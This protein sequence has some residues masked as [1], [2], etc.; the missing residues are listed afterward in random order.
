MTLRFQIS[1]L[2][3]LLIT[4]SIG[5]FTLLDWYHG[6]TEYIE[7]QYRTC[8]SL[9]VLLE[10]FA[11]TNQSAIEQ[12]LAEPNHEQQLTMLNQ[13]L[14]PPVNRI[15]NGFPRTGAGYYIRQVQAVVAFGPNFHPS[16]LIDLS[17]ESQARQIY[18]NG[19]DL[20]FDGYS[21]TR[22]AHVF[23]YM[24]PIY[25]ASRSEIIGHFWVNVEAN[26]VY[27]HLQSLLIQ[28]VLVGLLII[29]V[30]LLGLSVIMRM[31]D[32]GL[33]DFSKLVR[34][35]VSGQTQYEYPAKFLPE[36]KEVYY[37]LLRTRE[38][39]DRHYHF[40]GLLLETIPS[41]VIAIDKNCIIQYY[42]QV[43]ASNQGQDASMW[44]GKPYTELCRQLELSLE[45]SFLLD[46]LLNGRRHLGNSYK[47]TLHLQKFISDTI[48]IVGESGGIE[49]AL[50]VF[51]D[52]SRIREMEQ[53]IA[54]AEEFRVLSQL[55]AS[56]SHEIKNPLTSVK[57]YLELLRIQ[58]TNTSDL[59]MLNAISSEVDRAM[60]ITLEFLRLSSPRRPQFAPILLG[61]V[62]GD[63]VRIMN[64][65][66]KTAKVLLH[67]N[68]E[69]DPMIMGDELQLKQV[70]INYIKNAIEACDAGKT[71]SLLLR[72]DTSW[73]ILQIRDKGCGMTTEQLNHI[74]KMFYTTKS[75][76]S[77]LGLYIAEEGIA[78]HKGVVSID[79]SPETGTSICIRLPLS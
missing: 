34:L 54:K 3:V 6:Q 4:F 10:Q 69:N 16:G 28:N 46:S 42:N 30:S 44:V 37:E 47:D 1:L 29:L 79:S 68:L 8:E 56:I 14:Q 58:Q 13:L 51:H 61:Q 17:Q 40:L 64:G 19:T 75:Y 41:G 33:K 60:G 31:F 25:N 27:S 38:S 70:L 45:Q 65:F 59:E 49:G 43:A 2:L 52:V 76:G 78:H 57:S 32:K 18:Q 20:K 23:A 63:V 71:V 9:S 15:C 24:R 39:A 36:L 67:Y 50:A 66:A 21:Q 53:K 11:A 74:G 26:D 62:I 35:S 22:G 77:G 73:A 12:A 7:Q 5:T 72:A 48:P 55:A